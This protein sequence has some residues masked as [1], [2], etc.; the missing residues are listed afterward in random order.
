MVVDQE[1]LEVEVSLSKQCKYE[2]CKARGNI[3]GYCK[4]HYD[5]VY[6]R[7]S[8]GMNSYGKPKLTAQQ[9]AEIKRL[10]RNFKTQHSIAKLFGVSSDTIRRV[11][12][13][14]YTP[15]EEA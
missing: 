2:D 8:D 4:P 15:Q 7:T 10:H 13:G 5:T 1:L 9:V 11:T 3:A 12:R 6:K 14:Q